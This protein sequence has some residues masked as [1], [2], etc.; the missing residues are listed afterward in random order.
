MPKLSKKQKRCALSASQAERWRIWKFAL[1]RFQVVFSL[2]KL[3]PDRRI[4]K[5]NVAGAS[6]RQQ[7]GTL[8]GM[9]NAELVDPSCL[10]DPRPLPPGTN[11]GADD[12]QRRRLRGK[13]VGAKIR[14]G[15]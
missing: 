6:Q 13:S 4:R 2:P 14:R 1:D 8:F 7:H 12:N 9:V 5:L 3:C 15:Q 11:I 10:Y